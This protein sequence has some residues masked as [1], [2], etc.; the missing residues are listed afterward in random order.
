M[1]ALQESMQNFTESQAVTN[2]GLF[3][4]V[5]TQLEASEL[6]E[7]LSI[8]QVYFDLRAHMCN[9]WQKNVL[10]YLSIKQALKSLDN[11]YHAHA[12]RVYQFLDQFG[13]INSG[14]L[15]PHNK[16]KLILPSITVNNSAAHN[17]ITVN[18]NSEGITASTVQRRI[19]VIGA[20][21]SGLSLARQLASFGHSVT[22]LEGRNRCGGRVCTD[23]NSFSAPVDLGASIITGLIG[24]PINV[25]CKQLKNY[26]DSMAVEANPI[27]AFQSLLHF[28]KAECPIY[29]LDGIQL[30]E[31]LDSIEQQFNRAL[32]ATNIARRICLVKNATEENNST[33]SQFSSTHC[34]SADKDTITQQFSQLSS[35]ELTSFLNSS[36]LEGLNRVRSLLKFQLNS[37]EELVFQWHVANLE[38]GVASDLGSVSMQHWDQDD[39]YGFEGRMSKPTSSLDPAL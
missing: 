12:V 6:P 36:L 8:Q 26:S 18:L 9:E 24:N 13:F 35:E 4:Y 7:F 25:L 34:S 3:P 23:F 10:S 39:E 14:L 16:P 1:S 33:Q 11:K 15:K 29:G 31:Q 22:I 38:Y 20:G 37:E 28:V 32:D 17:N 19:L 27:V 21:A 30:S 2:S 5:M